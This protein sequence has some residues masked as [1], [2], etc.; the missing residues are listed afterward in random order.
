MAITAIT[1]AE[2]FKA[3]KE[4]EDPELEGGMTINELVPLLGWG[5]DKTRRMMNKGVS[6]GTVVKGSRKTSRGRVAV[7]KI[8]EGK[9]K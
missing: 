5:L 4:A 6:E 9:R 3:L 8:K 1:K 2:W 7:Y